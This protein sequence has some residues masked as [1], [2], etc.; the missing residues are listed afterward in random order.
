MTGRVARWL[1]QLNVF[2][3]TVVNPRGLRNQA[4]SNVLVKL[5]SGE[6]EPLHAKICSISMTRSLIES[7]GVLACKYVT[8][9]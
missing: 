7:G 5:F 6:C 2:G 3:I 4:L 9:S 1:Q 8:C